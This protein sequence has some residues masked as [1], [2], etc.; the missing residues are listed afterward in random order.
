M[1]VLHVRTIVS[2]VHNMVNKHPVILN[3]VWSCTSEPGNERLA[4]TVDY[5]SYR[6]YVRS[7]ATGLL[8]ITIDT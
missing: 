3:R 4:A 2:D 7:V 1:H 5:S 6:Y 8:Y